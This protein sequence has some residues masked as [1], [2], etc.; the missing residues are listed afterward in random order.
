[1]IATMS[2][3]RPDDFIV[4]DTFAYCVDACLACAEVLLLD[5]YVRRS[6]HGGQA[7]LGCAFICT[8]T[9]RNLACLDHTRERLACELL[10]SCRE[11]CRLYAEQPCESGEA[12]DSACTEA[13]R[14]CAQA[15]AAALD[16]MR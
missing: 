2:V 15:C 7:D 12:P 9:A 16:L 6:E 13:C 4:R 1:M 14:N 3:T 8:A 11:V 5:E 10:E